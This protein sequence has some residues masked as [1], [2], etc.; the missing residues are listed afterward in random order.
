MYSK[1][2]S[3]NRLLKL[4]DLVRNLE[5][6]QFNMAVYVHGKHDHYDADN[7]GH[8]TDFTDANSSLCGTPACVAGWATKVHPDLELVLRNNGHNNVYLNT[9]EGRSSEHYAFAQAFGISFQ[10]AYDITQTNF[11]ATAEEKAEQV[12]DIAHK[13]A[14]EWGYVIEEVYA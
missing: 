1:K 4:A 13:Y 11:G 14:E 3:L 5:P 9:P 8:Y 12:E 10:D 2:A 6:H 7:G